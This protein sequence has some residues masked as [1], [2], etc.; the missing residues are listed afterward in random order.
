MAASTRLIE[1]IKSLSPGE[2]LLFVQRIA[3][4]EAAADDDCASDFGGDDES[5]DLLLGPIRRC[6][7][8]QLL[9]IPTLTQQRELGATGYLGGRI[10]ASQLISSRLEWLAE[11]G[12]WIPQ[13]TEAEAIFAAADARLYEVL[14]TGQSELLT[15][16]SN[17]MQKLLESRDKVDAAVD[18]LSLAIF[19]AFRRYALDEVYLEVL[20]RNVYPNHAA[21][22]AACFAE[23][24]ALGSRCDSFFDMTPRALGR[25]LASRY[26]A[27]YMEHQ[28]PRRDM[29]FTE[30]PTAYAAMQVDFDPDDG[31][32]KLRFDYHITFFGIFALP[33]LIDVSLLTTIGRGL[34]LTTFMTSHEKTLATTALMLALLMSGSFGAWIGTGGC[35][36]FY[37]NAFPAMNMFV[38]T[39]F[40]AGLALTFAIGAGG[41]LIV[42]LVHGPSISSALIFLFY[43][44][45]LS[46]YMLT[47]NALA[48]Y[49]LPG[50]RFLSGRTVIVSCIP[51]LF[52][53]PV[54][55]LF[56]QHDIAVYMPVLAAFVISLMLGARSAISQWSSWYLRIPAVTD[57]E[58]IAWFRKRTTSSKFKSKSSTSAIAA[59][60]DSQLM[61]TARAE[62]HRVV[63]AEHERPFWMFWRKTTGDPLVA[64]LAEGYAASLFLMRWYCRHKHA[65]MPYPYSSTWNLTLK[66]GMENMTN[67]QKGLR[68]HSAFLHWR[69]T[70]RD[71]W[72]GFLYFIVALLDKW[73]ALL[74]GG[75]LVGLSAAGSTEFRLG[76]GFG[77]CYYLIG[78]VSLDIV[79]QPLWIAANE[80][81]DKPI[82]S[83]EMLAEV[84]DGDKDARRSLYWRSLAKFFFLHIWGATVLSALMWIFQDSRDQ[85]IMFLAYVGAYAGLLWYQYNKI[86]CGHN[87]AASLAI[88]AVVGLPAGFAMHI[89]MPQYAFSGVIPLAGAT[90]TACVHSFFVA[91]VIG[92][93]ALSS[94]KKSN[95]TASDSNSKE[96]EDDDSTSS[97]SSR[98]LLLKE[99]SIVY[100]AST[101][102]PYSEV[103]QTTLSKMF[104]STCTL[105]SSKRHVLSPDHQP[106]RGRI[107]DLLLCMEPDDLDSMLRDAFPSAPR[108]LDA[109]LMNWTSGKT[110]VELVSSRHFAQQ[111]EQNKMR[112]VARRVKTDKDE[113]VHIFVI[114]SG[115]ESETFSREDGGEF[116]LNNSR[117]W[118]AVAEAMVSA[119]C[120]LSLGLSHDDAMLAE[121][122]VVK[123][124]HSTQASFDATPEEKLGSIHIPEGIRRR[125]EASPT[126]RARVIEHADRTVLRYLL[127]GLDSET[128]W[129]SLPKSIRASLLRRSF[130]PSMTDSRTPPMQPLTEVEREW[131]QSHLTPEYENM[132]THLARCRLGASLSLAVTA[133]ARDL[134]ASY[135][136]DDEAAEAGQTYDERLLTAGISS[137][138]FWTRWPTLFWRRLQ[139]CIKFCVLCLTADPEYQ[140]ELDFVVRD[141][142]GAVRWPIV[143]FLTSVWSYCKLLQSIVI[144]FVF[145]HA[146]EHVTKLRTHM[147]GMKTVLE[148]SRI[149]TESFGGPS[150]L[151]W[152]V[153]DADGGLKVAQYSGRHEKEP[154]APKP[155]APG[156]EINQK[157]LVPAA[158]KQLMAVNTYVSKDNLLL[159]E[160]EEY[161]NGH[162]LNWFR[163][164]Y[165]TDG[166]RNKVKK[167]DS[168]KIPIQRVCVEGKR[169][170]ELVQYSPRG[171]ITTGSA[172]R[173]GNQRVTWTFFYRK[174]AKYE[175]ELL[176]A[177]Y[178]FPHIAIK[179][180]WSMPPRKRHHRKLKYWLPFPAV[181]EATFTQG[182]N[183]WHASWD[184]EHKF[185]PELTV[186]LNGGKPLET[187]PPMIAEDWYHVLQKPEG[188]SSFLGE[189]PLLSFSGVETSFFARRLGLNSRHF[190]I[191][192]SVARTQLWKAWKGGRDIDAISARWLDE[193]LL[194]GDHTLRPYWRNRDFGRLQTA[195]RFLDD[196]ADTVMAR[197]DVDPQTSSWVH[198]AYKMSDLYGM[199]QGGDAS[200]NTRT[201]SSQLHDS[202]DEKMRM[203]DFQYNNDNKGDELHILA[204]DTSTW[205]NDPGGV[206]ACRRDMVNDLKTVRW[207]IVAESANDY[208]V[209]RFQIE[210]NVQSLT[211]LPL[212]GLDFLNPTHGVLESRL[213][214]A[215]VKRSYDTRTADIVHNFLP[216]L[217]SL[218]R[219]A[220]TVH[221]TRQDIDEATRALVDLNTY[222]ETTRNWND[223]WQ[224]AVVK[225]KWRQLW[226]REDETDEAA[227]RTG[228]LWPSEWWDF[229]RPSIRQLD[230]AL[231]LWSRY[232]FIFS[233]PVPERI[234]DVFQAS[235]HFTGATYG[236]VCKIKR[237][238]T[239]HI[240]DHCISYRE[241]TTFMSSAVSYDAAFVNSSL[242]SLTHLSCVLLEHHADV[243]LPCCDYFNPGWEVE[244]GTSEGALEHRRV[245]ERKIDPV[246]NGICNMEKFEPIQTIK[247]S[248]PTV[249]ML[250]H[251]QYVKD[252][253]NAIM[254]TDL[255][256]NQWGF[257]D[258]RLHIYG[259]QERAATIA[260]ECQELI[261][262]KGLQDHCVLKGLGNPSMV[263]QDAWLFLNSSISEGLP[264]AMGEAALTG[265]PVVCTDVGASY[266]V[267]T[268]R[269]TGDRFSEVVPPNDSESLA[270]AQISVLAL[271]GRWAV[272]AEDGP[273]SAG[274]VP[275]LGYPTPSPEQ[276]ARIQQRMY[277]KSE[278]R[279]ALGMR[280]R[281]NVLNN[282]SSER[283]L[284]EHEQMLWLGKLRSP[285]TRH[286]FHHAGYAHLQHPNPS[287][288]LVPAARLS[289]RFPLSLRSASAFF[290]AT[291]HSNVEE[292][293]ARIRSA[294][295]ASRLTPQSWISLSSASH[296]VPRTPGSSWI[297]SGASSMRDFLWIGG[298]KEASGSDEKRKTSGLHRTVLVDE[299]EIVDGDAQD[300]RTPS[301]V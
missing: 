63:L 276:V 98:S 290:A 197:V 183:Q 115:L 139:T 199:G 80:Q 169:R 52:I 202:E 26:R 204:M 255:I 9:E 137:P 111:Q 83:F 265:V 79:S 110:I 186:T 116:L 112:A 107:A 295:R 37:A 193:Q 94:G 27:Y 106:N 218:V 77:L 229:E 247:T 14:M 296:E 231:D 284:R 97:N 29:D 8:Y 118:R 103:S 157:E 124:L 167:K 171:H 277:D 72:A 249:V 109:V 49:Q 252:I 56:T 156:T 105:P 203:R 264:L 301:L 201:V 23:N 134:D 280:G 224:N 214:S 168:I 148:R 217:A 248:T 108:L 35:Y 165:S 178:V 187:P 154:E 119:T 93:P 76:V 136:F 185:H 235:H 283:Y 86:Y 294:R 132:E 297:A 92:W 100:T 273:P 177:E 6:C 238:C 25:I 254:A 246:V 211:I 237:Q 2:T 172:I 160:R 281:Q 230:Q 292:M 240:W 89:L 287:D 55:S 146:N 191:P 125:L 16:I 215:V 213:D 30:L 122:L 62:L 266:C 166:E 259:D 222:F 123:E 194:R 24:F 59:M 10:N 152:H 28:P 147:K 174:S 70:G 195:R 117:H 48:I 299:V 196:H 54:V 257:R 220:R 226:L 7:E 212:W 242:I 158:H 155:P 225:E 84:T 90:W 15:R 88:G 138:G 181:T 99:K 129:D 102:E 85:T 206:S 4:A 162:F 164:E 184:Y 74:T 278:Q 163:Y 219:T 53:S 38:L 67:M 149:V 190:P 71:I 182:P 208:G 39:R 175:D 96:I 189:N 40:A 291:G 151:F 293:A 270:R 269:T 101:L 244:L 41:F 64:K 286:A 140:R 298:G 245:F 13:A 69:S 267:V 19:S 130:V 104:E 33:A 3:A 114:L 44:V 223:V 50:S 61:P 251:V 282:F 75:A 145:F 121:L 127:L 21:D 268:D 180:L 36:Y 42:L 141:L 51:I 275:V 5:R 271:L 43:F 81:A 200:I 142:P 131:L 12:C 87:S 188:G 234:P 173:E 300:A 31:K 113:T 11:K 144:P 253:K 128:E 34:Y 170:G 17:V 210:R 68:L 150:T 274:D 57:A 233:L 198:I 143:F 232:L 289:S 272:Y 126:E 209:P 262:A 22:Q 258:Y 46:C 285:R 45:V 260:T 66:A 256:V 221:L 47:L 159:R 228:I 153:D 32:E 1:D 239:L 133:L 82:S 227:A 243:V 288:V 60:T 216:I 58:V 20:D 65:R 73:V 161:K 120:E 263:L 205:P 78:A 176:W 279:R 250:S 207:H 261:A 236:I 192:T 241:F 91:G 95:K 179:V 18:I 135:A